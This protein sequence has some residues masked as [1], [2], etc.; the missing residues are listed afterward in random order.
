MLINIFINTFSIW[1]DPSGDTPKGLLVSW[2]PWLPLELPLTGSVRAHLQWC[3]P[4]C[5]STC[6][7]DAPCSL[8]MQ[9]PGVSCGGQ[10]Q[11]LTRQLCRGCYTGSWP[12][13]PPVIGRCV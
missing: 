3:F 1:L 4:V 8:W 10:V 5:Y 13:G 12:W 7:T 9:L 11:P 6:V 2:L